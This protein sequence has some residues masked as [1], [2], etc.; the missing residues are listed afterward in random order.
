LMALY[1][2]IDEKTTKNFRLSPGN[3]IQNDDNPE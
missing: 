1:C 2:S 3:S